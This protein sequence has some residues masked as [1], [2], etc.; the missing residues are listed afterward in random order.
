[1]R[2]VKNECSFFSTTHV[3]TRFTQMNIYR[4]NFEMCAETQIRLCRKCPLSL[5]DLTK[6]GVGRHILVKLSNMQFNA[7]SFRRFRV[8]SCAG[9]GTDIAILQVSE[10]V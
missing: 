9:L 7:K 1:M 5:S 10:S 2:W 3:H 6:I 4:V 8:L